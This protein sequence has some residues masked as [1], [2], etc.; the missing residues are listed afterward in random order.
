MSKLG[1]PCGHTISDTTD[2]LPYKARFYS[3]VDDKD[4]YEKIM[5]GFRTFLQAILENRR[6]EW[7]LEQGFTEQYANLKLPDEEI[8]HDF[9]SWILRDCERTIY[10]C[11][12]CGRVHIEREDNT[13]YS[14][15]PEN[16]QVHSLFDVKRLK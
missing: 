1:C 11:T 12:Q 3:D 2:L 4:L 6:K 8:F 14:Y 10:E 7:L 13:F 15:K 16:G 9:L 5:E